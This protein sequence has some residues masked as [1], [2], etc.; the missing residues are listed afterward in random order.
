MN[1]VLD[2]EDL[3][4]FY[5]VASLGSLA[6]AS[7][8][9]G[10][11]SPTI[12]RK[13]LELE[14][15][16]QRELFVRRQTG[17]ALAPD[18]KALFDRVASMQSAAGVVE[19]W[20][21]DAVPL[22]GVD[23]AVDYWMARFLAMNRAAIWSA[24]DPFQLC[25]QT[26][27]HDAT[28]LHRRAHIMLARSRP[29]NGNVALRKAPPIA[30]APY[31]ARD[32]DQTYDCNWI[33]VGRGIL[34]DPW[35]NWAA[36]QS[37]NWITFWTDTPAVLLDMARAGAGRA[38]LPC[39]I[40]DQEPDLVRAGDLIDDLFH[41]NWIVIHDDERKRPEVRAVIDRMADLM[42]QHADLLVGKAGRSAL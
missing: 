5:Q 22:P 2:W 35:A 10:I 25:I 26:E 37:S 20:R 24:I 28:L 19:A 7:A 12:G 16:T 18:G 38:V 41:E 36:D 11:S 9:T 31:C 29:E 1:D 34:G 21:S 40:G 14:R 3:R 8:E 23:I 42:N 6:A 17:Y 32:F 30:Y 4:L 33:S 27:E 13:M 15:A 39:Y